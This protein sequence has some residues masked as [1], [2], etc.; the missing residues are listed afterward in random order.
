LQKFGFKVALVTDG[1]MSGASGKVP[2]AIHCSP[3][4]IDGGLLGKLVDGDLLKLDC[5]EGTLQ[6][7]NEE[8]VMA[9]EAVPNPASAH[10]SGRELFNNIRALLSSSETGA[11]IF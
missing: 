6:C 5:I 7:L 9:R 1:R 4:A 10:G 11:T 2:A 3:E 8:E